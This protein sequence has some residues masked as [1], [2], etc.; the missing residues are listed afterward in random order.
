[1]AGQR[2]RQVKANKAER[3]MHMR[4]LAAAL[5]LVFSVSSTAHAQSTGNAGAA[6]F[7]QVEQHKC[8][9]PDSELIKPGTTDAYNAQVKGFNDCLRIY[10]L[11]EN[12]KISLIRADASARLDGIKKQALD[13]I[14]DIERAI[15][16]AILEVSIVNGT[17]RESDLPPPATALSAFPAAACSKPD[18]SLLNPI[19]GNHAAMNPA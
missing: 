3:G 13:Q 17:A 9:T 1:M 18:P 11:N 15:D 10:V 14:R 16:T 7:D 12:N 8:A 6:V 5:V 4:Q 2:P 19:Q